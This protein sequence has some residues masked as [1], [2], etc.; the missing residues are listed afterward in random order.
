MN[1]RIAEFIEYSKEYVGYGASDVPE[2]APLADWLTIRR[3]CAALGD[4]NPLYKDPAGGVSTKYHSMIAPPT[5][6]AAI[7]TPTAA[8][9]YEF[10]DFGVTKMT[11]RVSMEWVDVIRVGDR[12]RSSLDT[13][14][15]GPGPNRW[16]R[17]TAEVDCSA[18][19][20]NSYGGL[21]ATAEATTALVPY[22]QGEEMICDREIYA[23]SDDEIARIERGIEDEAPPRGRLLRYQ[24]DVSLGERLPTLVK[25]P[26]NLS[27]MMA[28]TVAEQKTMPLG[29]PVY[30]DLKRMPGRKRVNPSTNWP[31]WDADQEYED[32]LSCRDAGFSAPFSR[33]MHVVCLAGQV[34]T[35][36]MGDDGFLRSLDVE[37]FNP[38]LYGDTLWLTGEVSDKFRER[39]GGET[40][41]AVKVRVNGVNQ[42]GETVA[43]GDAVAYLPAPGRPPR[44]PIPH[45]RRR[46]K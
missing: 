40:Y 45:R 39:V 1:E 3:F 34:V 31:F 33:G 26:L 25:G 20:F 14:G 6:I 35:H 17:P 11:R 18:A 42:L 19:Y 24:G 37:L 43:A 13:E 21:I 22:R 15:V 23:Y 28:W 10:R 2:G 44:L 38:F 46:Q 9:A 16:G 5:F 27:D 4:A 36:W 32:I 29:K 8:G 41:F 7:R 12:L 30:E